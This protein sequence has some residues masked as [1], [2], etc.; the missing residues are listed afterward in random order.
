MEEYKATPANLKD[1]DGVQYIGVGPLLVKTPRGEVRAESGDYI[2]DI[3]EPKVDPK[4]VDDKEFSCRED[5][6]GCGPNA[7]LKDK[8]DLRWVIP[9]DFFERHFRVKTKAEVKVE[10]KKADYATDVKTAGVTSPQIHPKK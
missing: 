2:I 6:K 3:P 9:Q 10:D 4:A 8:R 1:V 5:F 7:I